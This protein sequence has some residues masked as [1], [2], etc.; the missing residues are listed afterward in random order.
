MKIFPKK[1]IL[2]SDGTINAGNYVIGHWEKTKEYVFQ[3]GQQLGDKKKKVYLARM[4]DGGNVIASQK[5]E[6]REMLMDEFCTFDI[7]V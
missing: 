1:I 4:I 5:N 2:S 7:D 3:N 6:L